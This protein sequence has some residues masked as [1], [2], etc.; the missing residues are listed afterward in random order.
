MPPQDSNPQY[1]PV[2][3]NARREGVLILV[4]WA[5]CMAWT[6]TYSYVFGYHVDPDSL[7]ITLGIPTWI[8]WGVVA[9]WIAA[10]AFS[11]WFA[12]FY[13]VDDD[14]GKEAEATDETDAQDRKELPDA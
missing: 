2:Y 13:M 3:V 8:V 7:S 12:L 4:A 1:D 9:P 11:C 14:L 10:T 5:V 6:V